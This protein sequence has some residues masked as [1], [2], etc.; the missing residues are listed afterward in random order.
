MKNNKHDLTPLYLFAGGLLFY[1]VAMPCIDAVSNVFQSGCNRLV[2]KW[3]MDLNEAQAESDATV[4]VIQPAPETNVQAIGFQMPNE[5][6]EDDWY[7][8]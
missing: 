6:V 5:V 2:A 8:E 3:Q 1:A 7:E 4:A